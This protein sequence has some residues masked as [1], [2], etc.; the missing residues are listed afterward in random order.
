M[1][2]YKGPPFLPYTAYWCSVSRVDAIV[3]HLRRFYKIKEPA[4]C[5]WSEYKILSMGL[6][7][8]SESGDEISD[9]A[10]D[11]DGESDSRKRLD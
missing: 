2:W 1:L 4:M 9:E 5:C 6:E 7:S 11:S 3:E 8:E 10:S